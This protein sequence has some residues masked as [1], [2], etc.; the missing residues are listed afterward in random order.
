MFR[1]PRGRLLLHGM[2]GVVCGRWGAWNLYEPRDAE[3]VSPSARPRVCYRSR[4]LGRRSLAS[5][6]FVRAVRWRKPR[7]LSP[8]T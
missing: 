2:D 7:R 3:P 8:V 5:A 6:A 1:S 4:Q